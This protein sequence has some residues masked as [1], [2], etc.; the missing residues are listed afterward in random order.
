MTEPGGRAAA[1]VPQGRT[2]AP[3]PPTVPAPRRP[4]AGHLH[5]LSAASFADLASGSGDA[6]AVA[7]L[8]AGQRSRAVLLLRGLVDLAAADPRAAGPLPPADEAWRLLARA[9]RRSAPSAT[10]LLVHPQ[11]GTWLVRCLRRLR[12]QETGDL[13][14]WRE[15]GHVH[16]TAASAAVLAGI[17]FHARVPVRDGGVMLPALGFA[18]LR[19]HGAETAQV[20][21]ERGGAAT[22]VAGAR[23]VRLPPDPAR[24]AAGWLALRRLRAQ[25]GGYACEPYLDDLDPYR[26]FL[27]PRGPQRLTERGA[28]AWQEEFARAWQLLAEQEHV[29]P[30]GIGASLRSL[31]PV[32]YTAPHEPFSASSP[33]AYGSAL[34]GRPTDPVSLA[35]SLVHEAQHVKLGAL[36]DLVPLVR[37]GREKVHHAPWRPDPRPLL[38]LLQGVYAFLGVTGFWQAR[39]EAAAAGTAAADTAA[40]EFALR[41]AQTA[42]GVRTLR[43]HADLTALGDAFL[44]GVE[45]QLARW[46]ARAVPDGPLRTAL[47][48][49]TDHRIVYRMHH[50]SPDPRQ[51][52]RWARAWRRGEPPPGAPP[53]T[54]VRAVRARPP[55]RLALAR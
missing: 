31:V 54:S 5:R 18:D 33:E 47:E 9:E 2:Q 45:R 37:G 41:R 36:M 6:R 12:G 51:S 21:R 3:P 8:S 14:L 1:S 16:A 7:E 13:P 40:F 20:F 46:H 19:A 38:G 44:S 35:A 50:L 15:V 34:L 28:E 17:D 10:A 43:A 48:L 49:V 25:A 52:A 42:A 24:D 32:P 4:G 22:V 26:D 23:T 29:H 11:V 30:G 55:A 27:R 39:R 53:G